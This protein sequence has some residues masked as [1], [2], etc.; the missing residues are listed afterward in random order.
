VPATR[1]HL[2]RDAKRDEL[3]DAAETL[4]LR[5]GYHATSMAAIARRAGVA[6]NALYWYFPSKD[7]LLAAILRRRQERAFAEIPEL[8]TGSVAERVRGLLAQL[9][10]V[11]VLAAC[12]HERVIHSE[13]VA[14]AHLDFHAT[15]GR[16]LGEGFIEAGLDADDARCAAEAVIAM[17]DG[18]HLHD[19]VRDVAHRDRVLLWAVDRMLDARTLAA[20]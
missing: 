5:S 10:E 2:D 6:N 7:D 14:E 16:V 17:I 1:R 18:I 12:I 8:A 3:L 9:D 20:S 11:A 15:T 13:A 4:M 19:G